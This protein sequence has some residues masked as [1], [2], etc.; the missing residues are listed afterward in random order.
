M[1]ISSIDALNAIHMRFSVTANNIANAS[2]EGYTAKHAVQTS[3]ESGAV[4]VNITD[5][6]APV[7]MVK[8]LTD[9]IK[10][11]YDYKANAVVMRT[12]DEMTGQVID[13]LA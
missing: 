13:I 2:T 7:D 8:E 3:D 11:V 10:Q 12:R 4:T 9:Q 5:T 1:N 6:G